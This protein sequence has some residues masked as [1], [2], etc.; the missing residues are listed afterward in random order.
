MTETASVTPTM[1][2]A[3][4]PATRRPNVQRAPSDP[5]RWLFAT[6]ALALIGQWLLNGG[7][8]WIDGTLVYAVAL[9]AFVRFIR[10]AGASGT[11]LAGSELDAAPA[12]PV[13][14]GWSGDV[15]RWFTPAAVAVPLLA[16]AGVLDSGGNRFR[17]FGI[18]ALLAAV[19]C[20]F[21]L[22]WVPAWGSA[23]SLLSRSPKL[24]LH[25]RMSWQTA[26]LLAIVLI[27]V[28]FRFNELND[29]PYEMISDHVEKYIDIQDIQSGNFHVFFPRNGGREGTEFYIASL[30]TGFFGY[31][32]LTLKLVMC[33]VSTLE[34][35]FIY[36]LGRRLFGPTVGLVAA[37]LLAIS[38]WDI[39]IARQ[40][41]RASF[42]P[43]FATI[44]LYLLY[45]ALQR[46]QR[47]DFLLLG[48]A[49][50]CG[51][52]GY[53]AF[54]VVPA[55]VLFVIGAYLLW[56]RAWRAERRAL[57][58]NTV[59]AYGVA[60]IL[61]LPMLRYALEFPEELF[62]RSAARVTNVENTIVG[63]PLGVFV[64]N[65]WNM[66]LMFNWH[67]DYG[68]TQNIP[69]DPELDWVTGALFAVGFFYAVYRLVARRDVQA[70]TLV[71]GIW[72]LTLT[73]TAAIAFPIENPH[74]NRASPVIPI[75]FT[76]AALP[77]A[78][79][80]TSTKRGLLRHAWV[81]GTT[82][83]IVGAGIVAFQAN[84]QRYFVD[85]RALNLAS[86]GNQKEIAAVIR[87]DLP[88][89]GSDKN[90]YIVS[91]PYWI[92]HRVVALELGDFAWREHGLLDSIELARAQA[93]LPG[94]KLYILN[95]QDQRSIDVL[96]ELYP[97]GIV[98]SH[99]SVVSGKEFNSFL[100]PG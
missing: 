56:D 81:A 45:R 21:Y 80:R 4:R 74:V 30:L 79:L 72:I 40:A 19:A 23:P 67:G 34:I 98:E 95:R 37:F 96:R 38:R 86:N 58:Q 18:L 64:H 41:F 94:P 92:D 52:Y 51:L 36:L 25:P 20:V 29:V 77:V 88:Q 9:F 87:S 35:P 93:T 60:L 76:I 48:L 42:S 16:V 5:R 39:G 73:S 8:S 1:A 99:P 11:L 24:D 26:A 75:V 62:A 66:M 28:F 61:W 50:G 6:I 33:V 59:L 91:Y 27:A 32:Y 3:P 85:F 65:V 13:S 49:M 7:T 84:Y 17:P 100:V 31:T 55:F 22:F 10:N 69:G 68:W 14:P 89:I 12:S 82:L 83:V 70:A 46:R 53:T 2:A 78:L 71:A 15:R 43:L 44:C 57:I 90:A 47:N 54:R 97:Q 63:S